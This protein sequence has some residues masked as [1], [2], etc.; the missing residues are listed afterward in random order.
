MANGK[1]LAIKCIYNVYKNYLVAVNLT[2]P[3]IT[4]LLIY[5]GS[6]MVHSLVCVVTSKAYQHGPRYN[7]GSAQGAYWYALVAQLG[8]LNNKPQTLRAYG[9]ALVYAGLASGTGYKAAC[10]LVKQGTLNKV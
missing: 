2:G 8:F 3:I 1:R 10:Q 5:R 6:K 9:M 7:V 4:P